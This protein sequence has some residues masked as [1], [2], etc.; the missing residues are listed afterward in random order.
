[1]VP[2][3]EDDDDGD[4]T[5]GLISSLECATSLHS[6]SRGRVT[7]LN[8]PILPTIPDLRTKW[9]NGI[10]SYVYMREYV[11]SYECV[12]MYIYNSGWWNTWSVESTKTVAKYEKVGEPQRTRLPNHMSNAHCALSPYNMGFRSRYAHDDTIMSLVSVESGVFRLYPDLFSL[13]SGRWAYVV[14]AAEVYLYVQR[15]GTPE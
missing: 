7:S 2:E 6:C 3:L 8:K 1:M 5:L 15:R 12:Y 13:T 11:D 14:C 9:F 4:S 10:R